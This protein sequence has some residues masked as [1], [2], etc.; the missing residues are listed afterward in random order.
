MP[1]SAPT[2]AAFLLL[3]AG[4]LQAQAAPCAPTATP[5]TRAICTVPAVAA[6]DTALNTAFQTAMHELSAPAAAAVRADQRSWLLWLDQVCTPDPKDATAFPSC[7][8][9]QYQDRT[10]DLTEGR[11]TLNGTHFY[12]RAVF[13]F[14]PAT[15][16]PDPNDPSSLEHRFG[17]GTFAWPQIDSPGNDQVL[18]NKA[19]EAAAIRIE[20]RREKGLAPDLKKSVDP[21]G[22]RSGSFHLDA[23]NDR[24]ISLSFDVYVYNWG[25]AHGGD[26]QTT[27]L[28]WLDRRRELT[29]ADV[30][31]PGFAWQT[32]LIAPLRAGLRTSPGPSDLW[33]DPKELTEGIQTSLKDTRNWTLSQQGLTVSF[34]EYSV[35]P[36]SSGMPSTTLPWASLAAHLTST[37][38]P[39]TLPPLEKASD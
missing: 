26:D 11:P 14:V 33:A 35:G 16:P 19:S 27:F 29:A 8:Q 2:L 38:H 32:A 18:W 25:A 31:L 12:T 15:T 36:Y 30:F 4:S 34:G 6:A 17:Y 24:L 21:D 22:S 20:G 1:R 28:W 7:L 23:V 3:T 10:Q 5:R 37:L 13:I 9:E 39:E